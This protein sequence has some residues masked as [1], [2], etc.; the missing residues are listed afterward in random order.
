[1]TVPFL[2]TLLKGFAQLHLMA[3]MVRIGPRHMKSLKDHRAS[4]AIVFSL[5]ASLL[6]V[7]IRYFSTTA[8]V[9]LPTGVIAA[10]IGIV[11]FGVIGYLVNLAAPE[12][13]VFVD[14]AV[15]AESEANKW[16]TYL[17]LNFVMMLTVFI[18]ANGLFS[19]FASDNTS[20]AKYLMDSGFDYDPATWLVVC[21]SSLIATG[22]IFTICKIAG[23]I[24][25]GPRPATIIFI[26]TNIICSLLY[27]FFQYYI[28]S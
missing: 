5:I 25:D 14:D 28:F 20:I 10:I 2:D 24:V 16:A 1:M 13:E 22:L 6:F 27:Y 4:N 26:V 19:V 7:S 21:A 18:G 8:D 11:L 12:S 3:R 15:E 23:K 9:G 17:S